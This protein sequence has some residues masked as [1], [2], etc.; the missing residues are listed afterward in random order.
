VRRP[1]ADRTRQHRLPG[2]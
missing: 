2:T 1:E